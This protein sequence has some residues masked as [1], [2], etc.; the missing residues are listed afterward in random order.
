MV[1]IA[2]GINRM[3]AIAAETS[4]STSKSCLYTFGVL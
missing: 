3:V 1:A 4:T 2:A